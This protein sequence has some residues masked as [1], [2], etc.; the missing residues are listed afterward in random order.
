MLNAVGNILGLTQMALRLAT[1]VA[2]EVLTQVERDHPI[3]VLLVRGTT[4]AAGAPTR[5]A[6]RVVGGAITSATT[7]AFRGLTAVLQRVDR[8]GSRGSGIFIPFLAGSLLL[9]DNLS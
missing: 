4:R 8:L 6:G 3:A 2:G 1:D 9:Y 5:L 7:T